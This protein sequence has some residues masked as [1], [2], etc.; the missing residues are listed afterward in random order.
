MRKRKKKNKQR[1]GHI[2]PPRCHTGVCVTSSSL[3]IQFF[4]LGN[5]PAKQLVRVATSIAFDLYGL[6]A[7]FVAVP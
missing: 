3:T 4:C 1:G 6:A 5:L 7:S 2:R